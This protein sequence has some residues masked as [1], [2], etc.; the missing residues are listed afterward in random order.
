MSIYET[1]LVL[2]LPF[3]YQCILRFLMQDDIEGLV[4]EDKNFRNPHLRKLEILIHTNTNKKFILH[5]E[6]FK[7][8]SESLL[9]EYISSVLRHKFIWGHTFSSG[10][11]MNMWWK[12]LLR[13]QVTVHQERP[14][15]FPF[16]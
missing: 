10:F 14:T 4:T 8:L 15:V 2:A 3:G 5:H 9:N 16:E 11:H 7:T 13:N 6:L 1:K 12:R